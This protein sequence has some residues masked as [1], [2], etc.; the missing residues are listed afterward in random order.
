MVSIHDQGLTF[1]ACDMIVGNPFLLTFSEHG[2]VS[3]TSGLSPRG[4]CLEMPD[5]TS[6]LCFFFMMINHRTDGMG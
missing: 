3:F 1:D 6:S 2:H 4:A 5:L